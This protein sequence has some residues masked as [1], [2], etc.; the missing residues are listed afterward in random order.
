MFNRLELLIQHLR[1]NSFTDL[2][3]L[4]LASVS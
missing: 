3:L 1:N 4:C 2:T